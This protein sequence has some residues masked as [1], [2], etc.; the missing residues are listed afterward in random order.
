MITFAETPMVIEDE[1][2]S[3]EVPWGE[4][5][6]GIVATIRALHTAGIKT[7]SSCEGHG[8]FPWV[9]CVWTDLF[10]LAE[11]LHQAGASGFHI[12]QRHEFFSD[13]KVVRS[14]EVV[15]WE[16]TCAVQERAKKSRGKKS[17]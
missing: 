1:V 5:D 6:A 3:G 17:K 11:I 4:L 16:K 12:N 10:V 7:L 8:D 9:L 13:K 2:P 15:F 14:T